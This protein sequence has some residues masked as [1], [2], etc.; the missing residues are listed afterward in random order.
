M[1]SWQFLEMAGASSMRWQGTGARPGAGAGPRWCLRAAAEIYLQALE[2]L[3][4]ALA[5]PDAAATE[6]ACVP[7][8]EA[9]LERHRDFVRRRGGVLCAAERE[10]RRIV[11]GSARETPD[12]QAAK[13]LEGPFVHGFNAAKYVAALLRARWVAHERQHV[14]LWVVAQDT[15]LFQLEPEAAIGELQARKETGCS[16]TTRPLAASW[17]CCLGFPACRFASRRLCLSCGH[18]ACSKTVAR[19]C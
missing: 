10:R 8:T 5:G 16:A 4:A 18:C 3:W 2:W 11:A 17:A 9:E 12:P 13:F 14:L 19:S 7:E 1:Q 6:A 15:P